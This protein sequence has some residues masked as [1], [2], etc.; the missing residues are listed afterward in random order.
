MHFCY[1]SATNIHI[2]SLRL[3]KSPEFFLES[4]IIKGVPFIFTLFFSKK[5]YSDTEIQNTVFS[6]AVKK[7]D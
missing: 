3:H 2:I 7:R 5:G 1:N 6:A 4:F